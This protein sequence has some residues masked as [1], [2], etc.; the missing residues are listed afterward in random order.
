MKKKILGLAL[1]TASSTALATN[2][3]NMIGVGPVARAMGGT[4]TAIEIG[5]EN[6]LKN[7]ALLNVKKELE[8]DFAAT[9]FMPKVSSKNTYA[10]GEEADSASDTFAIPAIGL[11][12]KISDKMNFGVG[13]YGVSGLGVDYRDEAATNGLSKMSTALSLFKFAPSVKYQ[14]NDK[15]SL[16]AGISMLH[17]TL[18]IAYD[19]PSSSG[20]DIGRGNSQSLGAGYVI[21]AAYEL[22]NMTFGFNYQSAIAMKYKHQI[23]NAA[24]DFN[25]AGDI[26]TD[27]LYQPSEMALGYA[28]KGDNWI[29][30]IDYR[31]I[32][33]SSAPGY[34]DFGWDDQTVIALGGAYM[35]E[36]N[37]F[38]LGYS[39]ANNPLGDD[40]VGNSGAQQ[41][42]N[43]L[44]LVGFPATIT[45]HITLGYTRDVSEKF[46]LDVAYVTASADEEKADYQTGEIVTNHSQS[47]LSVG[48]RWSF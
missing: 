27:N 22:D 12:Y 41:A 44:N 37:T 29:A 2:G 19:S 13:A 10:S 16:G 25:I 34:E 47:S 3:D 46:A 7:P 24:A 43:V 48:G 26:E 36:K 20:T 15:L 6:A 17:G 33:W 45:T 1:M 4:G 28:Y 31:T 9:L 42:I 30:T 18:S 38:R 14:V 5:A 32:A 21:G 39:T 8:V 35:M 11:V 23:K 40:A